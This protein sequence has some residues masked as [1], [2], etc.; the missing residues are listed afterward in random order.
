MT[1]LIVFFQKY[2]RKVKLVKKR[3]VCGEEMPFI[4][5]AVI[6]LL[7]VTLLLGFA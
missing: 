5:F 1:H 4:V 6:V 2:C 7:R 3:E